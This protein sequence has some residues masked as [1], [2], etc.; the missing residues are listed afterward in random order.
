MSRFVAPLVKLVQS[1]RTALAAVLAM[2]IK[3]G[4]ALLTIAVFTLAARAMSAHDFGELAVWFNAMLFLAV[5]ATF[6]QDTLIARNWG[7]Y[8]GKG[9]HEAARGAY[10]FGW[11]ATAISGVVFAGAIVVLGPF[12]NATIAPAALYAGASFMF[13]QTLLHYSSH[14]SRVIAGFVLSEVNRELTWRLVLLLVVV[15]SILHRGL[16][17]AQFFA[18]GA[19]GMVLSL[20]VQLRGVRRRFLSEPVERA[21]EAHGGE[22]LRRGRAMWLSAIVEATSQY[23]DVMLIG[24]FASPAAAGDYFVAARIANIFLMVTTGL[25]TYSFTHSANLFFSGRIER[26]QDIL[27]SVV[28]AAVAFVLPAYLVIVFFGQTILTIFGARYASVYPTL[29]VL[30]S[31]AFA[32]SLCGSA[33]VILLTTGHE[34]LYSRVL[35]AAMLARLILT[36]ALAWGFGA[37]GAA[38][39]WTLVNAPLAILLALICR[40]V[41]GVDP[42]IGG[43]FARRRGEADK[44][45]RTTPALPERAAL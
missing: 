4:G 32:M 7:E 12:A 27:R 2:V 21:D 35:T 10:R 8:E 45:R 6:G 29:V 36:A 43:L 1:Q 26:L 37:L 30:A 42:S 31:G 25:N 15:W 14:S 11:R 18:A 24:Y 28:T 20:A 40:K 5:A 3:A 9:A 44:A 41:C 38:C 34:R 23:A 39:A 17:P 22:W 13:T 16:T 33:S 19:A